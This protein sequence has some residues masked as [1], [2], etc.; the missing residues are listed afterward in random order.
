MGIWLDYFF[1]GIRLISRFHNRPYLKRWDEDL[2]YLLDEGE[3]V[4]YTDENKYTVLIRY[5]GQDYRIWVA[6]EF[7]AYGYLIWKGSAHIPESNRHR[8]KFKT[9]LR[10][11]KM[12]KPHGTNYVGVD[13]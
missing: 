7:F 4:G 10:L 6:D 3:F 8:P 1:H 13:R 2:N 12:I 11:R 9:M 5:K